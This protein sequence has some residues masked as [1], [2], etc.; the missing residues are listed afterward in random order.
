MKLVRVQGVEEMNEMIPK[1]RLDFV[2]DN[3]N[4]LSNC[5]QYFIHKHISNRT[6]LLVRNGKCFHLLSKKICN[7]KY[8]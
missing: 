6:G 7:N 3:R 4:R 2:S 8:I 5:D 1:V